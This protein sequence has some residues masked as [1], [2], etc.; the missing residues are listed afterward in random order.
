MTEPAAPAPTRKVLLP[1]LRFVVVVALLGYVLYRARLTTSQGWA[2]LFETLRG[3]HLGLLVISLLFTPLIHFQSTVKWWA[4]TRERQMHVPLRRLYYYYLVGR[5]YNLV[6][7]SNIGGD[8]IRIRMLGAASGRYADAAAT[9][10]VE[11][12]TGIITLVVYAAVAV[13]IAAVDHHLTWLFYAVA[14]AIA[15]LAALCWAIVDDRPLRVVTRWLE[16]R[17]PLLDKVIAKLV[18]LHGS[19]AVFRDLPS[20][21]AVAFANSVLFYFLAVVNIWIALLVFDSSTQLSTMLLAVPIAM[22]LMNIPLSVG[23]VGVIEFAYTVVL[24][25]FGVGAQVAL[26]A[27]V[28][29]RLKTILAAAIGGLAHA[30]AREPAPGA[31]VVLASMRENPS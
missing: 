20:A 3:S 1:V 2:A 8:L 21:L 24:G 30:I 5:F 12:L 18:R 29:M 13:A 14:V 31:D 7:P 19:I 16:G 27:V 28:L 11:R 17:T 22:F 26:S 10:I 4:L 6:L 9:V 25:A 15:A 23:N